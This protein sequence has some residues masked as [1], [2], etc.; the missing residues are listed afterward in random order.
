MTS[1]DSSPPSLPFASLKIG[2][3]SSAV[4]GSSSSDSEDTALV[5][6]ILVAL[7]L[8]V[9]VVGGAIVFV[10]RA[11][12]DQNAAPPNGGF[13]N[14]AYDGAVNVD[15]TPATARSATAGTTGYVDIPVVS[16]SCE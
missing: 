2:I 10:R 3:S 16:G 13:S 12:A 5:A 15:I 9:G 8:V 1:V 6:V 11:L 14:P 4:A 7:L